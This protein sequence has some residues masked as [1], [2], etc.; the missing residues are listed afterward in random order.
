MSRNSSIRRWSLDALGRAIR[1]AGA[2]PVLHELVGRDVDG[3]LARL[4]LDVVAERA[5]ARIDGA[6]QEPNHHKKS[7]QARHFRRSAAAESAAFTLSRSR[8]MPWEVFDT[9]IACPKS[10]RTRSEE[11]T[12]ELQSPYVI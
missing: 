4:R 1:R 3:D 6:A 9:S 8:F 10:P 11:H 5:D 7:E 2:L 12:S